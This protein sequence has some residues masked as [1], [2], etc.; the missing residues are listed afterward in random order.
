MGYCRFYIERIKIILK[1]L[2]INVRRSYICNMI[3][4]NKYLDA[5]EAKRIR[6]KDDPEYAKE[7]ADEEK[8]TLEDF[9]KN[10]VL[11]LLKRE[12]NTQ[13]QLLF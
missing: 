2:D 1:T 8:K 5:C 7:I 4:F 6:I 10:K 9:N 13:K 12:V 11:Y 3:N